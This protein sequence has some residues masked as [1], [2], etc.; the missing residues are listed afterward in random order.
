[1]F[2]GSTC[3]QAIAMNFT[4]TVKAVGS[5]ISDPNPGDTV[6]GMLSTEGSGVATASHCPHIEPLGRYVGCHT[7]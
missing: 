4:A 2:T 6:M 1:M 5:K 7:D 3:P